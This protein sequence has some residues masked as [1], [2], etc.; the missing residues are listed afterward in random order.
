[1]KKLFLLTIFCLFSLSASSET[2][3]PFELPIYNEQKTFK[4]QDY[5]GKTVVINFFASWCIA[6]IQEFG[7]LNQLKEKNPSAIFIAVNAGEEKAK[8]TKLL[9]KY[10]FN[11]LVLEDSERKFSKSLGIEELPRT[12]IVNSEGVITYNGKTP[13][14][15]L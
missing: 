13:P 6:C 14:K 10:P 8:I 15:N 1:M 9:K 5:K 7:E 4:L 2:M 11:Y 3:K 12:I